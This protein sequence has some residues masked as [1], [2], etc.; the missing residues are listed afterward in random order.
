MIYKS[1]KR[2]ENQTHQTRVFDD[3]QTRV[4]IFENSPQTRV[5]P[6]I[7]KPGFLETR[8][9]GFRALI[10]IPKSDNTHAHIQM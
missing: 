6:V 5:N 4:C 9:P 3:V 2:Q 10:M 8:V 7:R 1:L